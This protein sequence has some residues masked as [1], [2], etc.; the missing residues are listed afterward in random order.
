MPQ[1][2]YTYNDALTFDKLDVRVREIIQ[3]DTGQEDW[4]VAIR[5]P[6]LGNPP[7]V[8]EDAIRKLEAIEG[9]IID[10]VEGEGDN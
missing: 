6:P 2:R 4:P 8:S 9:V 3:K 10:R 7:P 1:I 5:D